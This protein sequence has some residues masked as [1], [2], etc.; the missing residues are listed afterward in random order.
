MKSPNLKTEDVNMCCLMRVIAHLRRDDRRAYSNGGVI[1]GD[2]ET[3][4]SKYPQTA[5]I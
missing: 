2:K 5:C 1:A 3:R 4:G